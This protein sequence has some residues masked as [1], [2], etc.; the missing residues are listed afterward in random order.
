LEEMP[1]LAQ[2]FEFVLRAVS[3]LEAVETSVYV[4]N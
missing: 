2:A 3:C 4:G 1:L